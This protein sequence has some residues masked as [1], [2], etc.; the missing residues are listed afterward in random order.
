MDE[1]F[2]ATAS[3]SCGD[4]PRRHWLAS[5]AEWCTCH[6]LAAR[7]PRIPAMCFVHRADSAQSSMLPGRQV[8]RGPILSPI[9]LRYLGWRLRLQS[10]LWHL[11]HRLSSMSC[12]QAGASSPPSLRGPITVISLVRKD[13]MLF[14]IYRLPRRRRTSA[15]SLHFSA[16]L[17]RPTRASMSLAAW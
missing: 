7:S 8:P 15:W 4:N 14:T 3:A 5:S 6:T 13:S 12:H 2:M 11:P 17:L 16:S 10:W 9:R 1:N